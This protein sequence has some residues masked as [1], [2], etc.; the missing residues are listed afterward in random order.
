M[1]L[2]GVIVLGAVAALLAAL[3]LFGDRR[4]PAGGGAGARVIPAFDRS[5]VRRITIARAGHSPFSL[6]AG[7][8]G[9]RLSPGDKLADDATVQDLIAAIDF[10]ESQRTAAVTAEAAGLAPPAVAITID[11]AARPVTLELGRA[12]AAGSGV[13]V[14][15]AGSATIAVAPRRLLELGDRDAEAF[16]DRRLIPLAAEDVTALAWR[17]GGVSR[18]LALRDGRWRNERGDF[19]STAR[20]AETVRS[21][22]ALRI[23]GPATG[24]AAGQRMIAMTAGPT[25]VELQLGQEAAV[26]RSGPEGRDDVIAAGDI[27]AA[28][29]TLAR[30]AERDPHLLSSAPAAV[31]R[32][33]LTEGAQRLELA[34]VGGSWRFVAPKLPY[35]ADADSVDSW[36]ATLASIETSTRSN[37]G[38]VRKL[39]LDG[40]QREAVSVSAP[41]DVFA[42]LAPDPLRFRDRRVLSFAS[43]DARRLRRSAGGAVDEVVTDDGQS[44]RSPVGGAVDAAAVARVV[45]ALADLR[46]QSFQTAAPMG[47]PAVT[48]EIDVRAPG[49][50]TATRH[51]LELHPGRDRC[52]ARL[53]RDVSFTLDRALCD[54]LRSLRLTSSSSA[55]AGARG[56][57]PEGFVDV[58]DVA[59]G[60]VIDMRYAGTDN[61][62][63]RPARGYRAP[64][65]LLT[66]AAATALAAAHADLASDGFG[67]KVYDCY[68]PARAV[69]DFVAWV[70]DP[71]APQHRAA[72]NPMVP[73]SELLARG[74]VAERSG[75]S[76]G[77]TIDL[78]LVRLHR[79]GGAPARG[80]G[81]DGADCRRAADGPTAPDGS[82]GMGTTFDCFDPRAAAAAPGLPAE[83]RDNRARLRRAMEKRG[84][85]PYA[86]EWW[87]FTLTPEPFPDR[88][89]DSEIQPRGR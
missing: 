26:T 16:R 44:W 6:V 40:A 1:T 24:A 79:D 78:T 61:F 39:V 88:S 32:I 31:K 56:D 14:R 35:D 52:A 2:R 23:A 10:A 11:A 69:A 37:G 46:V 70:R 28:W 65:C 84:F 21:L 19:V 29:R 7:A 3:V 73:R 82:V 60:V 64:R 4:P 72:F 48:V 34:R 13:F 53:D 67:L 42:L 75:H 80:P 30:A 68:R 58:A 59:P 55:A 66:R 47:P 43:F 41:A 36:L 54:D 17:D 25:T 89:F 77:S 86:P 8:A 85:A 71:S 45:V 5:S 22:L 62:M 12:D 76:R 83:V 15:A 57:V 9:W 18:R 51:V 63:G 49:D 81:G 50:A 33:E 74:Y 38:R 20:V 87:H 27:Q